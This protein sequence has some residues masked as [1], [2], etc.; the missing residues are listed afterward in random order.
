MYSAPV[1]FPWVWL[2][3]D[4]LACRVG[5]I[6]EEYRMI[7]LT[8]LLKVGLP[9]ILR[10]HKEERA[11]AVAAAWPLGLRRCE[12]YITEVVDPDLSNVSDG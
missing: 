3:D 12:R 2:S 4:Q 6:E 5:P 10:V 1:H 7:L 11:K 9:E 8:L